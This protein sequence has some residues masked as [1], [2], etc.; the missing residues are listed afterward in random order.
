MHYLG[1]FKMKR[2]VVIT[3]VGVVS[4]LGMGLENFWNAIKEGKCGISKLQDLI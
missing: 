2:R 1:G 4:S 3:G